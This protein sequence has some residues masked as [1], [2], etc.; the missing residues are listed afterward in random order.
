MALESTLPG[1]FKGVSDVDPG[2]VSME[3]VYFSY[4]TLTTLGYGDISPTQPVAHFLCFA[5]AIVG[6]FYIAVLVASLVGVKVSRWQ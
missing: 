3:L 2:G 1:S 4:I 5:E 6:Q